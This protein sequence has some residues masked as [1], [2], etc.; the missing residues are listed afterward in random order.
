VG[1]L[2]ACQRYCDVADLVV[3]GRDGEVVEIDLPQSGRG[4]ES[5]LLQPGVDLIVG[6]KYLRVTVETNNYVQT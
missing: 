6:L 2:S 3:S 1:A 5:L 4:V